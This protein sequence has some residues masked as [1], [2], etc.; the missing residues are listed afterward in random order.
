M[1]TFLNKQYYIQMLHGV[2][3]LWFQMCEMLD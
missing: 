3:N 1:L 2:K